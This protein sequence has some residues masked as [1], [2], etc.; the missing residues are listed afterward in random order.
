[1]RKIW[2]IVIAFFVLWVL[3]A[4]VA[5]TMK[6]DVA[7]RKSCQLCGMYRCAYD[8]SRMLI[9]YDDGTVGAFCSIHCA[10]ID[11]AVNID[12]TPIAIKVAD[13]NSKQLINA[14]TAFWVVGGDMP[15]VMSKKGKWAFANKAEALKFIKMNQGQLTS[16]DYAM[17][18]AYD[19]MPQD[20][21]TI[22]EK[23]NAKRAAE[24][25]MA[26]RA[27]ERIKERKTAP[28]LAP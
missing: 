9:E 27:A 6:D 17:R 25:M 16:F 21:K 23:K 11:L 26:K 5:E 15:G 13:F 2:I 20:T 12:K 10:A 24:K 3:P 28:E 4:A 19:D 14:E 8:F 18:I 22:R 1:M 7:D